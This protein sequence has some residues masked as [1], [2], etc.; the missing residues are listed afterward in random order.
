MVTVL[1]HT[2]SNSFPPSGNSFCI[3]L[4]RSAV[5]GNDLIS[6]YAKKITKAKWFEL[7]LRRS[8]LGVTV[9]SLFGLTK[10]NMEGVGVTES[11]KS[12]WRPR[13]SAH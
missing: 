5:G 3:G 1:L 2:A 9:V 7:G 12:V 10:L 6:D 8:L 4:P 13:T 11:F